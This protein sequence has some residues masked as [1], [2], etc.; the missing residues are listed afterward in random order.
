MAAMRMKKKRK[1]YK[2]KKKPNN[3]IT[4]YYNFRE[5]ISWHAANNKKN[6]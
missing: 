1:E 2:D 3:N 6:A 5:R 4:K